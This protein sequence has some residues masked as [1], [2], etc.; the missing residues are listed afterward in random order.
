MS[1]TYKPLQDPITNTAST[2]NF[3]KVE[4]KDLSEFEPLVQE[5]HIGEQSVD[6]AICNMLQ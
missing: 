3:P 5:I 2:S 6:I 1:G 4:Y